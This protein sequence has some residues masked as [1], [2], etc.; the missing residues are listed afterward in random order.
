MK[1][2]CWKNQLRMYVLVY[3]CCSLSIGRT[4]EPC[5]WRALWKYLSKK[6]EKMV[7]K[8][9]FKIKFW[10]FSK[11]YMNWLLQI[12]Y[13]QYR[14]QNTNISWISNSYSWNYYYQNQINNLK[15]QTVIKHSWTECILQKY[16][17]IHFD[18]YWLGS[19]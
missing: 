8:I 16:L 13:I 14:F 10:N 17:M 1:V 5:F 15:L 12:V 4:E 19:P 7:P 6:I 3:E 2:L 18:A 11:R 9:N